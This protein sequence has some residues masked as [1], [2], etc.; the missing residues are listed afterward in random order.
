MLNLDSPLALYISWSALSRSFSLLSFSNNSS[1]YLS[2][3]ASFSWSNFSCI[4]SWYF[5]AWCTSISN[6]LFLSKIWKIRILITWVNL[7]LSSSISAWKS[8]EADSSLFWS[9]LLSEEIHLD[10]KLIP[11]IRSRFS[12]F[13][14]LFSSNVDFNVCLKNY[15]ILSS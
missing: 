12:I 14:F 5:D 8:S 3:I 2:S 15:Y 13:S 9:D 6:S 10:Y 7:S 4:S 11:L 1:S